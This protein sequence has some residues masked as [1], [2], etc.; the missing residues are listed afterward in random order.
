MKA[1]QMLNKCRIAYLASIIEISKSDLS[2]ERIPE[3]RE[4]NDVF[5]DDLT[6]LPSN[7]KIEFV[8][9]L[10]PGTSPKSKEPY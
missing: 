8:I 1:S 5:P 7:R 4:Y 3:V 6:Y 10:M 9:N 2:I